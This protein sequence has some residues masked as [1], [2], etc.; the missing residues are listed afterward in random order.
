M[1]ILSAA[2]AAAT[3][4]PAPSP[5]R[6]LQPHQRQNLAV[7]ALAGAR[8]ITQLAEEH[9]VSRKFVYQQADKA[10]QALQAAFTPQ[11]DDDT[12]LFY[13]P[14][15]KAWLRQL[16]LALVLIGHSSLRGVVE[17]LGDLFDYSISL[18]T[19]HNIVHSAIPQARV[20]NTGQNL[21]AVRIGVPDE[22]F[23]AG[24]PVL[25]GCD[26]DSTYCYLLSPEECRDSDTWAVRLLELVERG[27]CPE[28]TVADGGTA[29]RAA[30]E[31][32]LPDVPRRRDVFHVF[33]EELGPLTRALE[34]RAYQAIDR[35]SKLESQL[36][37]PGKRRDRLKMS[38][39]GKLRYAR[40]EEAGAVA[41][42]DD[43]A[44]LVR[45]LR[46]D[47]L[48]AAGTD[49]A[50]R[51]VLYDFVL[52][53]LR[54]RQDGCVHR[55]G[56]VCVALANQRD[57]LLA[58][59]VGLDRD[60]EA[61]AAECQVPVGLTREALRVQALSVHDVRRGPREAA[62]RQALRGRYHLVAEA[63]A[64]VAAQVVRAS[65]VVENL[66]SRLRNYF[67]LRRQVGPDALALLQFFLNH[68]RF[69]RSERPGRVGKS[70]AELLTGES[71]AHW[72]ELL[73]YR[74]FVQQ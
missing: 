20:H 16:V 52:S 66:N 72:L 6:H 56:P 40:L 36:A 27:F 59:A 69:L 10:D 60:L 5:A 18:G 74:R 68:R 39:I 65:S 42:A 9:Q 2:T 41:L 7:Q 3:A 46:E 35:R 48:A 49:H 15:T 45:W 53:E 29:L 63:V 44:L 61:V 37:R 21:S 62:L 8:P 1:C 25:V 22:I 31:L 12:V 33:Y 70:P 58:F 14:V 43:V 71:H 11:P 32:V 51:V 26:A 4:T 50:S 57:D 55:I 28:A 67:F 73:G 17:L 38:L 47:V 54:A 13:L 23:Q 19:V 24:V 34:A 64:A 30:H